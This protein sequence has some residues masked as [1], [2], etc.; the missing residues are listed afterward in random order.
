MSGGSLRSQERR[1]ARVNQVEFRPLVL[2]SSYVGVSSRVHELVECPFC[3]AEVWTIK[4]SRHGSGKRC[5]CGA[6]LC[7][8]S[9]KRKTR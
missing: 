7:G 2:V 6:V 4:W 9:A 3:K 1:K 5:S 8:V